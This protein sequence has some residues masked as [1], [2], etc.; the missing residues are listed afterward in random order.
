MQGERVDD[1][2][3]RIFDLTRPLIVAGLVLGA[4]LNLVEV[5]RGGVD[6]AHW[7]MLADDS[8]LILPLVAALL[9]AR[10]AAVSYTHLTLPTN[11]EV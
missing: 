8:E 2:F 9:F 11:R 10:R 4:M 7:G 6:S 3:E 5:V 1:R